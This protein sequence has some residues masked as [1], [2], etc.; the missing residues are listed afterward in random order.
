MN[1]NNYLKDQ[2]VPC[3][4]IKCTPEKLGF[5]IGSFVVGQNGEYLIFWEQATTTFHYKTKELLEP[6]SHGARCRRRCDTS[7]RGNHRFWPSRLAKGD[8]GCPHH[9]HQRVEIPKPELQCWMMKGILSLSWAKL[10]NQTR[11]H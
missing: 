9:P 7:L 6:C 2:T 1:G 8:L 3:P 4:K 11:P 5:S 10:A